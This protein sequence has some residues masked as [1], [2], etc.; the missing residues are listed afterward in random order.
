MKAIKFI[1][2][3]F[4]AL[5][6][7][8]CSQKPQYATRVEKILAEIND[9]NSDYIAVISH[10]G[11]WRNYPE[12]SIPAFQRCIDKGRDMIEIDIQRTKDGQLIL[13]HDRTVDR[14]TNGKGKV[15]D[16]TYDEIQRLRLRPQ[17]SASVTRNHIPTLEEVLL[18]CKGKILI[19]I[20]KGY[21]YFQQVYELMEKTGTTNQVIIKSG[22]SLE[23]VKKENGAV[24]DKVI[25]MPI[26]NLNSEDA[27]RSINEFIDIRPVAI[28][29]CIGKYNDEVERLLRKV[30]AAGIKV[31]INS[32]WSSLC[33]GHDDDRAVELGEPDES[34]GWILERGAAVIQTDRPFDLLQYLKKNKRHKLK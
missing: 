4:A 30:R 23:K 22:N 21:D 29:C 34:W 15:A 5:A 10:R 18:L 33:D 9:P 20:D 13:M 16:L 32:I 17:H 8:A 11:D 14:C 31:W 27:E 25:Y 1:L 19:N 12:N 24:L 3:A 6:L 28:E 26:V 2:V 7:A